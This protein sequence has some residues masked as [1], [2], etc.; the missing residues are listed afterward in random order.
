MAE[1]FTNLQT[2]LPKVAK[3]LT[4]HDNKSTSRYQ[5]LLGFVNSIEASQNAIDAKGLPNADLDDKIL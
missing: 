3:P 1:Q 2:K 4:I 5:A